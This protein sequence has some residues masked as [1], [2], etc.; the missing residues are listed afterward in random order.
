MLADP[1]IPEGA[2]LDALHYLAKIASAHDHPRVAPLVARSFTAR[3]LIERLAREI[4]PADAYALWGKYLPSA[5]FYLER[6]PYLVGT[7]PELRFGKSL[8]GEAPNIVVDLHELDR[9]T[10][11]GNLYVFTDNREKRERTAS[12]NKGGA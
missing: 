4:G 12:D 3:P 8:I 5:A 9:A 11:G 2:K 7:R 10:A 6:P 1:D